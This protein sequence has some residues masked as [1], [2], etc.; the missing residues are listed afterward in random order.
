MKKHLKYAVLLLSLLNCILFAQ[1]SLNTAKKD[2]LK[3][4]ELEKRLGELEKKMEENE[5]QKLIEEAQSASTEKKKE[6][7][8]KV[9]KSGQRALQA[10]NPEISVTGD[11]YG[12]FILN[13]DGFRE[14]AR[15]GAYFRT[16]DI[17]FQ[18]GLDPFSLTKAVVEFHPDGVELGEAYVTWANFLPKISLTAGKF[19]QQFGVVNRWHVHALDQFDYPLALTTILGEDGLNQIGLSF[20]WLMPSVTADANNLIVE[21]TN[22]QNN[23]LFG[24][25]LFSFPSI[26][27]HLKNY[28]D[29]SRDTYLEFGLTG[30]Y[31]KN[32]VKGFINGEKIIE[33]TRNTYLGGADLTI[34]WEPV[35]KA[36][37]KSLLWRSEIFYVDKEISSNYKVKAF[38]GYSY[39]EY[40]FAEQWQIG[41]R[42]DYTQPFEVSN[43]SEYSYQIVPYVTWW[44]SH[45]VRMRLQY[46]YMNG[47][48]LPESAN[49]LRL[50]MV[51]AV[52]PHKH[53]RY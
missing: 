34:F 33:N 28:Y 21:I 4:K 9:F 51:W 1:D 25:E 32:N 19:R 6:K 44:Q 31:G 38:G 50:Q 8:T 37:Y 24:G 52:G 27:V 17:H 18:G 10:I 45:W 20:N 15:T 48:V 53:D 49:T 40:K 30:M 46:S 26:L 47:N 36:L 7:K 41:A 12:Q 43:N 2:S 16:L 29:L 22:G 23:Q 13:K 35:N 5:L 42:F 3:I 39:L 14:G 11:A